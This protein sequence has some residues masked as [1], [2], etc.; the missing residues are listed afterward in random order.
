MSTQREIIDTSKLR[1]YIISQG[2]T[3]ADAAVVMKN[4]RIKKLLQHPFKYSNQIKQLQKEV[5]ELKKEVSE[6][7]Y[8]LAST[9]RPIKIKAA[10][11][12]PRRTPNTPFPTVDEVF[13]EIYADGEFRRFVVSELMLVKFLEIDLEQ[14]EYFAE[15]RIQMNNGSFLV[16]GGEVPRVCSMCNKKGT[17][18]EDFKIDRTFV[19][20]KCKTCHKAYMKKYR[21]ENRKRLSQLMKNWREEKSKK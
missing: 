20:A 11:R 14:A 6:L 1:E 13:A 18:G 4:K 10:P 19:H 8:T 2:L 7:E 21:A 15:K 5:T 16:K 9:D 3:E 12:S 17:V